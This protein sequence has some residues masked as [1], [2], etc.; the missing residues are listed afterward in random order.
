LN[1]TAEAQIET[2]GMRPAVSG[3]PPLR[4]HRFLILLLSL[5]V[6]LTVEGCSSF[7]R[8]L[9]GKVTV[10]VELD[11]RLNQ[12]FPLAVDIVIV[13]DHDLFDELK[14]LTAQTWFEM[15]RQYRLDHEPGSIE[16][17]SR[18]WVPLDE[19]R[20]APEP[21][22]IDHRPGAKGAVVFA[23]YFNPGAHRVV[24]EP[25]SDIELKFGESEFQKK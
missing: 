24:I 16:V 25:L 23:N 18:E 4:G 6:L 8:A 20:A 21:Y 5:A 9:G 19:S 10:T 15:R 2:L 3:D 13:Y 14:E 1:K 7:S 11:E 22:R 12:D 17:D